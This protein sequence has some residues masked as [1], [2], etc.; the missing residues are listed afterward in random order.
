MP[1]V[2]ITAYEDDDIIE[3]NE[4]LLKPFLSEDFDNAVAIT[5]DVDVKLEECDYG[6][7]GSPVWWEIWD[8]DIDRIY[9][10]DKE[11]TFDSFKAA[12]FS[13]AT[14]DRV[15]DLI[16]EAVSRL[17]TNDLCAIELDGDY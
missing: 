1:N 9:I 15:F 13:Q 6:V 5:A 11:Y 10:N 17:D 14:Q 12:G 7:P 8:Y 16:D 3:S 2:Y 4:L